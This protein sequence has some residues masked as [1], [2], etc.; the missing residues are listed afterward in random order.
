MTDT[1]QVV[2]S[3]PFELSTLLLINIIKYT[4]TN[5]GTICD[6]IESRMF[7]LH[8]HFISQNSHFLLHFCLNS[9][10]LVSTDLN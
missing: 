6:L 10:L 1:G 2:R 7:K 4:N 8:L 3:S 5:T 9:H